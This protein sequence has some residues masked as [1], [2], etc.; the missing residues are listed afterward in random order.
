MYVGAPIVATAMPIPRI[1]L[2]AMNWERAIDE[3]TIAEPIMMM[4]QPVNMPARLPYRSQSGPAQ[5]LR[6]GS[7]R[8]FEKAEEI[9]GRGHLRA[10]HLTDGV[11]RE[12]YSGGN[13]QLPFDKVRKTL[14]TARK[15]D[16]PHLG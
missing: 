1:N 6:K 11:N 16:D 2:P 12:D 9:N 5:S 15:T 4:R 13:I 10:S 7:V 14:C 3:E 8:V